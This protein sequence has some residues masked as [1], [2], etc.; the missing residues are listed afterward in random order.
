MS[1]LVAPVFG[2]FDLLPGL[3]QYLNDGKFSTLGTRGWCAISFPFPS[4]TTAAS[5]RKS[6]LL[7]KALLQVYRVPLQYSISYQCS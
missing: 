5:L 4:L 7:D 2:V 3:I 1:A 6:K